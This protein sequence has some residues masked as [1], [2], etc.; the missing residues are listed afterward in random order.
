MSVSKKYLNSVG[1]RFKAGGERMVSVRLRY[2]CICFSISVKFSGRFIWS[3]VC[4][5]PSLSAKLLT[6]RRETLHSAR[7]ERSSDL[8]VAGSACLRDAV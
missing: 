8:L 3:K 5:E 1:G 2:A 7:R 6:L 4:S